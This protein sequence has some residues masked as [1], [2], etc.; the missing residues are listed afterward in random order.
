MA[1][2]AH[3]PM[4]KNQT[5]F[6]REMPDRPS[7]VSQELPKLEDAR[8]AENEKRAIVWRL[9]TRLAR[10]FSILG[11]RYL[12]IAYEE[13][14]QKR[15]DILPRLAHHVG[16]ASCAALDAHEKVF[17]GEGPGGTV[18]TRRID[19][20]SLSSSREALPV[21]E[22]AAILDIAGPAADRYRERVRA[23]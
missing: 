10:D 11:S 22:R 2:L 20:K 13:L 16:F 3:I 23:Q 19:E 15:H 14:V 17:V 21:E 7:W 9:K 4:V 5:R 1:R 12:E 18:R 6:F 8:V